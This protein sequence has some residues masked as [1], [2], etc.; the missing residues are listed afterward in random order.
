M[1]EKTTNSLNSYLSFKLGN[2]VF[3]SHVNKVLNILEM[4]RITEVPRSP[5]YMKG[6]INLRGTVLP[7][8]DTRIKFGMSATE[9]TK[10]TCIVVLNVDIENETVHVGALVDSVLEVLEVDDKQIV[11]PPSIGSK[12]KSEFIEGM[13]NS[14]NEFIMLLNMDKV[15]SSD[16][17]ILLQEKTEEAVQINKNKAAEEK[18]ENKNE[19]ED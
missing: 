3:A 6:V 14:D 5:A 17:M 9:F 7:V 15:F 13:I 4:V 12:Y 1:S 10:N 2:E 19:K 16:E 8:I 18:N 11:P